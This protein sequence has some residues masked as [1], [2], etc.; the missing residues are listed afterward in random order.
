MNKIINLKE[1][2]F[3]NNQSYSNKDPNDHVIDPT[4]FSYYLTHDFLKRYNEKNNKTNNINFSVL[5][6]Y[7]PYKVISII[8]NKSLTT[9]NVNLILLLLQ[10]PGTQKETRTLSLAY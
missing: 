5:Q 7:A 4:N 3:D 2:N 8:L 9:L 6:T 10:K 1:L